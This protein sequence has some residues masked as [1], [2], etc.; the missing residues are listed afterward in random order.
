MKRTGEKALSI[1]SVVLNVLGVGILI[2]TLL[3]SKM[4]MNDP[5]FQTELENFFYGSGLTDADITLGVDYM[6]NLLQFISSIGWIFV[7]LGVVAIILAIVGAVKVNSNAK[8]AG[9][10]FIIACVL[11]GIISLSGILLLIAAIMCFARKPKTPNTETIVQRDENGY[12][13]E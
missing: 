6:N 3:G 5:M 7:L 4:L 8:L 11:S 2:L 12:I 13:I 1:I 9:I 10:L